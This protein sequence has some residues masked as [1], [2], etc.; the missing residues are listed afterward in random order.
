MTYF[1]PDDRNVSP[2]LSAYTALAFTW[3][4][5]A[6]FQPPASV[7]SRL[8][9]YLKNLL[10]RDDV[11]DFYSRNM[12]ATV[13]AV[14]L[15]ALASQG[16]VGAED[17]IR[18]ESHLPYMDLFGTANYMEAALTLGGSPELVDKAVNQVL[19]RSS[20]TGGKLTFNDDVDDGFR[21]ILTTPLRSNCAVLSALTRVDDLTRFGLGDAPMAMTRAITQSR[22]ARDHWENTQENMFCMN[23]L[24]D[25]ARRFE[26]ETPDL[27][28]S[29]T[30]EDRSMGE[31]TL[32]GFGAKPRTFSTPIA[33]DEV[34]PGAEVAVTA[35][36]VGRLYYST[37]LTYAPRA[38]DLERVNA[39]I[40]IRR[41]YAVQRNGQWVL[42]TDPATVERGEL[43]R[44]DLFLALPTARNFVVVDDPVPGGLEPV[45]RDLATTSGVDANAGDFV[46]AGGS[47]W[48]SSGDWNAYGFSRWSFY[49]RELGHAAV[50]F[51][52]DYLRPGRY[53]LSYTAQAIAA[54]TFQVP[55]TQASEMYDPDVY[56]KTLP[57]S[58][59]VSQP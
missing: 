34:G 49:H 56:G 58:L 53:H 13:R 42:L 36:G 12:S 28:A 32:Q 19:A 16:Q 59:E 35:Q 11:P 57:L 20:T 41:E 51:Y 21:R 8:Q 10:R 14:A 31:A 7:E 22:G 45:N 37:R 18:Y 15:N 2:Y 23:A 29:V 40:D 52:S 4:R 5:R 43:V 9:D 25:Y 6:G 47:Y 39:G 44:V 46:A 38:E 26:H 55:P 24:V 3:L 30:L 1:V 50:R 27:R 48:F 33:P 17:L 54:G